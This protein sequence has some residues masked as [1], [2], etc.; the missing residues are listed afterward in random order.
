MHDV[1]DMTYT[2]YTMCNIYIYIYIY[3]FIY[4]CIHIYIYIYMYRS[5]RDHLAD[6]GE[7]PPGDRLLRSAS[8]AA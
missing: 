4:S 7:V 3:L 5:R 8:D 2:T 6:V 1:W